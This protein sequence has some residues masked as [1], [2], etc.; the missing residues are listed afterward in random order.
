MAIDSET[1]RVFTSEEST[2]KA[3]PFRVPLS[4]RGKFAMRS[5]GKATESGVWCFRSGQNWHFEIII[6]A[7]ISD[8]SI[9]K[10]MWWFQ[11][12]KKEKKVGCT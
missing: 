3:L 10:C 8:S 1:D 4:L 2:T 12:C 6:K 11:W 9:Q 7:Y 5:L